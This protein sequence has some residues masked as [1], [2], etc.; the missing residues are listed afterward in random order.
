MLH[1]DAEYET[2]KP[3]LNWRKTN[4]DTFTST[5]EKLSTNNYPLWSSAHGNPTVYQLDNWASLL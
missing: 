4:W 1:P 3:H 2:P 5:L